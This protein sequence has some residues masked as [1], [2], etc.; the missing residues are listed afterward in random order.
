MF[1]F[2]AVCQH[3]ENT[4][5]AAK[6][7]KQSTHGVTSM[8]SLLNNVAQLTAASG[9]SDHHVNMSECTSPTNLASQPMIPSLTGPRQCMQSLRIKNVP[10][11]LSPPMPCGYLLV[12]P[13]LR[14]HLD[15]TRCHHLLSSYMGRNVRSA[16]SL[17]SCAHSLVSSQLSSNSVRLLHRRDAVPTSLPSTPAA[18][19]RHGHASYSISGTLLSSDVLGCQLLESQ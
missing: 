9:Q 1:L 14:K 6:A 17:L 11:L 18:T 13:H 4:D 16:P 7:P 19:K 2:S 10:R 5:R 3:A 15:Y 8:H 12:P